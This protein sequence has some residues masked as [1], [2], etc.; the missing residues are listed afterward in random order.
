MPVLLGSFLLLL[1]ESLIGRIFVILGIGIVTYTGFQVG[2]DTVKG[3][4]TNSLGGLSGDVSSLIQLSGLPESMGM[5]LSALSA[6]IALMQ[7]SKIQRIK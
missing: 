7:I 1:T 5:I 4:I 3:I 2:L 6:R